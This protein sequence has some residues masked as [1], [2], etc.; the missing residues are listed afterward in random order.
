MP[1][2]SD[3]W[4]G[5]WRQALAEHSVQLAA[6][7]DLVCRY[8]ETYRHPSRDWL[9][10]MEPHRLGEIPGYYP[11]GSWPYYSRPG[12]Y[13]ML[14]ESKGRALYVGQAE[15]LGYRLSD[16][17]RGSDSQGMRK[18]ARWEIKPAFICVIP[19]QEV[20]EAAG[21]E[22]YLIPLLDPPGNTA[23]CPEQYENRFRN[24]TVGE[25]FWEKGEMLTHAGSSGSAAPGMK[26]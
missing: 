17:F 23:G 1:T 7:H 6:I 5:N 11:V 14:D 18:I 13:I 4:S 12:V 10:V 8:H 19:V 9:R 21:L 16:W 20:H 26:L 15:K 2:D 25:T 24:M 3:K 22:R